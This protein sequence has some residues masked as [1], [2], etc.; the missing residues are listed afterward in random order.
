MAGTSGIGS[1][2]L[3]CPGLLYGLDE[4]N[5]LTSIG[6][7]ASFN[8]GANTKSR[9]IYSGSNTTG[10]SVNVGNFNGRVELKKTV[11]DYQIR[12]NLDKTSCNGIVDSEVGCV[13]FNERTQNGSSLASLSW[14]ADFTIDD[15]S[16]KSP[17]IGDQEDRNANALI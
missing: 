12:H 6:N 16:G 4:N 3:N 15:G 8:I 7:L 11:V 1:I 13:L 17:Q 5:N 10:C 14:D 2:S 9:L